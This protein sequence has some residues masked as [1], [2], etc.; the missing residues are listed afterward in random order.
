MAKPIVL[1]TPA[2]RVE[3]W[4]KMWAT[5]RLLSDEEADAAFEEFQDLFVPPNMHKKFSASFGL[6]RASFGN[7]YFFDDASY[8][9]WD[10]RISMLASLDV[11][12][13]DVIVIYGAPDRLE[14][15][16]LRGQTRRTLRDVVIDDWQ[17][18]C[19]IVTAGATTIYYFVEPKMR[20]CMVRTLRNGKPVVNSPDDLD[21]S[22]A[23]R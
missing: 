19:V 6:P 10:T 4:K 23:P 8:R 9:N 12:H 18:A 20:G 5:P 7:R 21:P 11:T 14:A 16:A 15:H 17:A 2:D 1:V 3:K 13:A 22:D